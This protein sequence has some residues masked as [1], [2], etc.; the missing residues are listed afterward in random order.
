MKRALLFLACILVLVG[1]VGCSSAPTEVESA[2]VVESENQAEEEN[3]QAPDEEEA[4]IEVDE[5]LLMVEITIP[6]DMLDSE[7]EEFDKEAFL[8]ENPKVESIRINEDG[9]VTLTMTK[10]NHREILKEM[11]TSIDAA[12]A[13]FAAPNEDNYIKAI[14]ASDD[15]REIAIKVDR[16]M[17]ESTF[18]FTSYLVGISDGMY[19]L[20]A[21]EEFHV[22]VTVLD[23]ETGD[24]ITT[25]VLPDELQG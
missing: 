19:Q 13:E 3:Q 24:T 21:G 1:M 6:V 10:K 7:Q 14:E 9:S 17:Y 23:A 22:V 18:D 5:G 15:Y 2:L 16:E 20:Y 11:K 8:A 12:F 4:I 25:V